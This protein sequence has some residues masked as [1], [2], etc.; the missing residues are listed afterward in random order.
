MKHICGE[1][2]CRW[3]SDEEY[4]KIMQEKAEKI[5]R[6]NLKENKEKIKKK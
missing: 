3:V 4:K 5:M 2:G 1:D 6:E